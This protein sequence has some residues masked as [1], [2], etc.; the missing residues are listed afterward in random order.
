MIESI[1]TSIG[2][3]FENF[4]QSVEQRFQKLSEEISQL[5]NQMD[6]YDLMSTTAQ[7]PSTSSN[8]NLTSEIREVL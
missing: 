7:G 6:H 4:N 8:Q 3:M 2:S 5:K 1:T